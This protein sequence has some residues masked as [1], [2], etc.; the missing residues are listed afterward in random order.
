MTRYLL[1]VAAAVLG[2]G[3]LLGA[4]VA[5]AAGCNAPLDAAE[6]LNDTPYHMTMTTTDPSGRDPEVSELIS[7]EDATYVLLR[8][9][10][11]PG[12]KEALTLGDLDDMAEA[13]QYMTC[14]LV[15]SEETAGKMADVW[16]IVDQS[17]PNELKHQ[18]V[19]IA[20]ETGLIVRMAVEIGDAG[21]AS[22]MSAEIDYENVL[23]PR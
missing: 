11:H 1:P 13:E 7:T 20:R 10:W 16:Q 3:A 4:G 2:A 9:T 17:D 12:P 5:L 6:K 15:R 8:G 22:R 14:E 19:W 18:T 23:P 21:S